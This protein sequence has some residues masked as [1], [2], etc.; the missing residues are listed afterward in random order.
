M[1]ISSVVAGGFSAARAD[2]VIG[3]A[4]PLTGIYAPLGKQIEIGAQQA[5]KEIN[6][7]G[8][9]AGEKIVIEAIDDKCKPEN[10]KAVA[11]Q[12]I[13]KD[14]TFVI[15][16]MCDR[17]SI[18]AASVYAE[19]KVIQIS[20]ASQNPA[21]TENRPLEKGGTYRF[22]ARNTQQADV[23][24]SFL[25]VAGAKEKIVILNDG[26]V[27]GK[28]LADAVVTGLDEAGIKPALNE[29]F[30]AGQERYRTL[31]SK[32]VDAGARF[33]FIGGTHAD[34][35]KI[36]RELDSLSDK[37]SFV[38]G[39]GL[40]NAEFPKLILEEN[41]KRANL[42]GIF[43]SFPPD[44]RFLP[45]AKNTVVRFQQNE[46]NPVGYTLRGY[47]SVKIIES[48]MRRAKSTE[49]D[50]LIDAMN[51]GK[52]QTPLGVIKFDEKGDADLVDY[53][54]HRWENNTVVP[55]N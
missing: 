44:P 26:S 52:F 32:I 53:T 50:A 47:S 27:Y 2:I 29:G 39:D 11:N 42:D 28:A 17:P 4:A 7:A 41:D 8:G 25:S 34:A 20:P 15:G 48:T 33:V 49:F 24:I 21:F 37:I 10:A 36:I 30:E 40:V 16:H 54:I 23:L 13:G 19:N 12:L 43:V 51:T 1:T 45:T 35:A 31:S 55:L 18:E 6:E 5:A 22:A 14:V 3:I 38:G 9:I 46:I